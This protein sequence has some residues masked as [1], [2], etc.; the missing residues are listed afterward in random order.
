MSGE[1]VSICSKLKG[2]A[3]DLSQ[4]QK[5]GIEFVIV[6]TTNLPP[7]AINSVPTLNILNNTSFNF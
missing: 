4:N 6:E 7:Q 3:L 5:E 1:R 2:G